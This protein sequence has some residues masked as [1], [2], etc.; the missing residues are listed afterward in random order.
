MASTPALRPSVWCLAPS[1]ARL[2]AM[3]KI[4]LS[5]FGASV[6]FPSWDDETSVGTCSAAAA[7]SL[8]SFSHASS[9][10]PPVLAALPDE[11][12]L[13]ELSS[14]PQAAIAPV[15]NATISNTSRTFDP[16]LIGTPL[17]HCA[18]LGPARPRGNLALAIQF[19]KL[20]L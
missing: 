10:P 7:L 9:V 19:I 4:V 3:W 13:L 12:S 20:L 17:R 6:T 18:A 1:N 2:K 15:A 8:A 14:P 16:L 5:P 11:L